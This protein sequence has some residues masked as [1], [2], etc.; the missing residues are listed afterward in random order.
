MLP[1]STGCG[2]V[3]GV[4]SQPVQ[5]SEGN[6]IASDVSQCSDLK[7]QGGGQN[8]SPIGCSQ[9]ARPWVRLSVMRI[10]SWDTFGMLLSPVIASA[11]EMVRM[12][13]RAVPITGS[14]PAFQCLIALIRYVVSQPQVAPS[15]IRSAIYLVRPFAVIPDAIR[16]IARVTDVLVDSGPRPC[17]EEPREN[18]DSPAPIVDDDVAIPV[19][20]KALGPYPASLSLQHMG[21]ETIFKGNRGRILVGHR[22][23]SSVSSPGGSNRAGAYC[24]NYTPSLRVGGD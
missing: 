17:R 2:L 6:Q 20:V 15:R 18:V 14:R 10:A 4:E 21:P 11:H 12:R 16:D 23:Y 8:S 9:T 1:R 22:A 13:V 3:D 19:R 7:N 5:P 24:V